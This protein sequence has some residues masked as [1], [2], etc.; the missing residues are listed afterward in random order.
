MARR[1]L[2]TDNTIRTII[3]DE[4]KNCGVPQRSSPLTGSAKSWAE[5]HPRTRRNR[6]HVALS[7][8]VNGTA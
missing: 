8:S 7:G 1:P 2:L 4:A 6:A 3:A 5:G